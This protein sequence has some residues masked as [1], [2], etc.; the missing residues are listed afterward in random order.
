MA[1]PIPFNPTVLDQDLPPSKQVDNLLPAVHQTDT[2]K[3]FFSSS[4][5]HLFKPGTGQPINGYIGEQPSY[6]D[7]SQDY[8][9][10][11]ST[12]GRQFYQ[13]EP[14][15]VGTDASGNIDSLLF[16]PDIVNQLRF[17]G[18]LVGNHNRLFEQDYYSWCPPIDLD[19]LINYREYYW[20][21]TNDI[22]DDYLVIERGAANSN[23]WSANNFWYHRDDLTDSQKQGILIKAKRPIVEFQ[24]DLE[25]Y[26]YGTWR[27]QSVYVCAKGLDLSTLVLDA[28]DASVPTIVID[29]ITITQ[30]T[31]AVRILVIDDASDA[32]SDKVYRLTFSLSGAMTLN[33][34]T[35]GLDAAGLPTFGEVILVENGTLFGDQ[36]LYY[37]GSSW[38]KGQQKGDI[39]TSPLFNLYDA[40]NVPLD[41]P[42]KYPDSNFAGNKI[43]SYHV[44]TT[45]SSKN[46][47]VLG[48]PLTF[49]ANGQINF[50]NHLATQTYSYILNNAN[51][52]IT[53][54][55]FHK[56]LGS[57]APMFRNDWYAVSVPSRQMMVDQ[58]ICDGVNNIFPI[59]QRPDPDT[60]G[61]PPNLQVSRISKSAGA[62]ST[63]TF[64]TLVE[65]VDYVRLD[66][67]IALASTTL[68]DFIK[69]LSFSKAGP[70]QSATGFYQLP[71]NLQ[72]NPNNDEVSII[73]TGDLYQQFS[74]VM[75][76]QIGFS[77]QPYA[78]NNWRTTNRDLSKGRQIVQNS[79]NLLTL[80]LTLQNPNLDFMK[81]VRYTESEYIRFRNK[82]EQKI[83]QYFRG[84]KSVEDSVT[85]TAKSWQDVWIDDALAE[86]NKG[87][88]TAFPFGYSRV[89][90]DASHKVPSFIPPSPT[91][92]GVYPASIPALAA[93]YTFEVA[94]DNT[95][96]TSRPKIVIRNHDGSLTP[97]YGDYRVDVNGTIS[98]LGDVVDPRDSVLLQLEWR[99]YNSIKPTI[100]SSERPVYDWQRYYSGFFRQAE[101]SF[102][103]YHYLLQPAFDRW[104]NQFGLDFRSNTT[105]KADD[106]FTWNWSSV[107]GPDG[108]YLPGNWRGICLYFFDTDR[109]HTAP[110]EMLGFADKPNYWDASY[111]PA[112]YTSNNVTMWSDLENGIIRSGPR[113]G[114]NSQWARPGLSKY[115]PVDEEGNLLDPAQFGVATTY[116]AA[117]FA[118]E[119][120]KFGDCGPVE[121][122]WRRSGVFPFAVAQAGYLMKPARFFGGLWNSGDYVVQHGQLLDTS[123]NDRP[124]HAELFVHGEKDNSGKI[125]IK[126]GIQQWIA[127]YLTSLNQSITSAF[128]APLRN[129]N[130]KLAYKVG[131]F[132]N[133]ND[134]F[135]TSDSFDR[136]PSEDISVELYQSPSIR[137]E[138]YSGVIITWDGRWFQ[139]YGYDIL[140]PAFK[141]IPPNTFGPAYPIVFGSNQPV[142]IPN[143]TPGI[144]Y[145]VST[146]VNHAGVYYVCK[147]AHTATHSFE[148]NFWQEIPKPSFLSNQSITWYTSAADDADVVAVPYGAKLATLQEVGNFLNG[149]QRYY[150]SRGWIFDALVNNDFVSDWSRSCYEFLAWFHDN[151]AINGAFIALSPGSRQL[152]FKTDQGEPQS[153]EQFINGTY[154]LV[155][156]LSKPISPALV[157]I[158]RDEGELS[159]TQKADVNGGIFGCRLYIS[160][161]EHIIVLNNKT[162]FNDVIYDPL[163]NIK[164]PRLRLQGFKTINWHGRIDAP[165]F[166]VSGN[167][168]LPN[169]EK[170]ADEFRRM[171]DVETIDDD[172]LQERAR[173][174]I[175]YTERDYLSNLLLTPTNQ[176][177]FYQGMIQQKGTPTAMNRLLRSNFIRNNSDIHF[178]EEWLFRVGDYGS[179]EVQPSFELQ[180]KQSDVS[181]DPQLVVFNLDNTESDL[182]QSLNVIEITDL[183]GPPPVRDPRWIWRQD[184]G[185]VAWRTERFARHTPGFLPNWGYVNANNVSW[186]AFNRQALIDLYYTILASHPSNL[187]QNSYTF[188]Y[189]GITENPNNFR[190]VIVPNLTKGYLRVNKVEFLITENFVP[191]TMA[192]NVGRLSWPQEFGRA[193][194][195]ILASSPDQVFRPS[196][197][198]ELNDFDDNSIYIEFL[199]SKMTKPVGAN[200]GKVKITV[201]AEQF[202][203]SVLPNHR[204]AVY[205]D[206]LGDWNTYKLQDTKCLICAAYPPSFSGQGS[207]VSLITIDPAIST[208]DLILLDGVENTV[209][210]GDEFVFSSA[211]NPKFSSV[212]R[213]VINS[214]VINAAPVDDDG[215]SAVPIMAMIP[216]AGMVIDSLTFNVVEPFSGGTPTAKLKAGY[217]AIK[218][219]YVKLWTPPSEFTASNPQ[220]TTTPSFAVNEPVEINIYDTTVAVSEDQKYV[221]L[222]IIRSGNIYYSL[223]AINVTNHGSGYVTAPAVTVSGPSGVHA[224]A[225]IAGSV[226]QILITNGGSGFTSNPIVTI[227]G[228]Y[229]VGAQAYAVISGGSVVA[230]VVTA[231]G[232]GYTT[233]PQ[234]IISGGGGIGAQATATVNYGVASVS[235]L[236]TGGCLYDNTATPIVSFVGGGG[237][238]ASAIAQFNAALPP[239]TVNWRYYRNSPIMTGWTEGG[240]VT[241]LPVGTPLAAP[242]VSVS[243]AVVTYPGRPAPPDIHGPTP[244]PANVD[245]TTAYWLQTV[246]VPVDVPEDATSIYQVEIYNANESDTSYTITDNI[247]T[248][249]VVKT[250]A[251]NTSVDLSTLGAV[252]I[253]GGSVPT[254]DK[255]NVYLLPNGNTGTVVVNINYHY[256]LGFEVFYTD[257]TPA[258]IAGKGYGGRILGWYK[259][260]FPT[261][262][263]RDQAVIPGG[264][265]PQDVVEVDYVWP[266]LE[267]GGWATYRYLDLW[268]AVRDGV[269]NVNALLAQIDYLL[270]TANGEIRAEVTAALSELDPTSVINEI[271]ALIPNTT[272]L[273]NLL[274]TEKVTVD[275]SQ[276]V[277][278]TIYN[279]STNEV[280]QTLQLFDPYQGYIVGTADKE[281]TYK[282][283]YD[284]ASYSN[285]S[286]P[287]IPTTTQICWG[288]SESHQLWWDIS[289]VRYID[290]EIADTAYRWKNWGRLAPGA[291]VDV[292]EWVRSPVP[293]AAWATYT[294]AGTRYTGFATTPLSGSVRNPAAVGWCEHVEWI[295]ELNREVTAYYFWVKDVT[296]VPNNCGRALSALQVATVIRNPSS[297]DV[298]WFAAI[299]TNKLIISG[300]KQFL[301][302][303]DTILK[304]NWKLNN[305]DGVYHKQWKILREGDPTTAIDQFLWNKLRDSLVGW[306]DY[307][308]TTNVTTTLSEQY[309]SF[310][311]TLSVTDGSQLADSGEVLLAG[312]AVQYG[313]KFNNQL[314]ELNNASEVQGNSGDT[315]TQTV[316]TPAPKIVP[317]PALTPK[318]ANGTLVRPRQSWFKPDDDGH[319]SR[320]AIQMFVESFNN[321]MQDQP[322]LDIWYQWQ[323]VFGVKDLPPAENEFQAEAASLTARDQL[324][325]GGQIDFGQRVFVPGTSETN[326]FWT[327]WRYDSLN[328]NQPVFTL[329]KAQLYDFDEGYLWNRVDWYA[330]DWDASSFPLYHYPNRAAFEAA[331]PLTDTL[332]KGTLIMID[333]ES[334]TDPRWSWQ[335][336]LNGQYTQVAKQN[337]TVALSTAFYDATK[338][339]YGFDNFDLTAVPARDGAWELRMLLNSIPTKLFSTLQMNTLFF[340]MVRCALSLNG[341]IDWVIKSSFMSIG[342]FSEP[343][344]QSPLAYT[345]Q[346][347]NIVSYV[348]EVKPYHVKIRNYLIQ[349]TAGRDPANVHATDFDCGYGV[350][351]AVGYISPT[352]EY[353][354]AVVQ[355]QASAAAQVAAQQ[356][357]VV[358]AEGLHRSAAHTTLSTFPS[359]SAIPTSDWNGLRHFKTKVLFDRVECEDSE[360]AGWD[361]QPWD[362]QI[363][364]YIS[365][366]VPGTLLPGATLIGKYHYYQ[367]G[368]VHNTGENIVLNDNFQT[369]S[370]SLWDL[371]SNSNAATRVRRFYAPTPGMKTTNIISGCGYKGYIFDGGPSGYGL[372]DRFAWDFEGGL[373]NEA[374]YYDGAPDT[375]V[376][377]A[378]DTHA[379]NQPS[380]EMTPLAIDYRPGDLDLDG[381]KFIIDSNQVSYEIVDIDGGR[382]ADPLI[383]NGHPE[384]LVML[385]VKEK[386]VISLAR[387]D[388]SG[389]TTNSVWYQSN[390]ID[391]YR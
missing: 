346:L 337:A 140:N 271:T 355:A 92:L 116:P 176:F 362:Y 290:Y 335:V 314:F 302:D 255:L 280:L 328:N 31:G 34:E 212:A 373:A 37:T 20:V 124:S 202:V 49:D 78:S 331:P 254:D 298:A 365:V 323:T 8:Y 22:S 312:K 5:N 304:V 278:A 348:E 193:S 307:T 90:Y 148:A 60:P 3:R 214:D 71:Q 390:E 33:L 330:D 238:G 209:A 94:Y 177:E 10:V 242:A 164:Q 281:L 178:L 172:T 204:V 173:S 120:W 28:N 262:T 133:S 84:G 82:F 309:N 216:D 247:A 115:I 158:A 275:S 104:V 329:V 257:G 85:P 313:Y 146:T 306:D 129:L 325:L 42:A 36:E 73:S 54:F 383:E 239:M 149:L 219:Y 93:D 50:E 144:Y 165:G 194:S 100:E 153:V 12:P 318:E 1:T 67:A 256:E 122:T 207:P 357:A 29:G 166:V 32:L 76:N 260:R 352:R 321:L 387:Q 192:I 266:V 74:Q 30:A 265:Q 125:V 296:T 53:G 13:L 111:G 286:D 347:S 384:E 188:T 370:P 223:V 218:D 95:T 2:I 339:R 160:E 317:D 143:W 369:N 130:V 25:L 180:L 220:I 147:R 87:K 174:N 229:G 138:F 156:R 215:F 66:G 68:N 65:N 103:E 381:G 99:I 200:I 47:L 240:V 170:S 185:Q 366:D 117:A 201:T 221:P 101:Y 231:G 175:G 132:T 16:Y 105:F 11:E 301:D 273:W 70:L 382:F 137:E 102:A 324:A 292:Y 375:N 259:T 135:V 62:T 311:T 258:V 4:A 322:F 83:T 55:Y 251:G 226:S 343:L 379:N 15:M 128:G 248:I 367:P 327:L 79:A 235:I 63:T 75:T 295:P 213:L 152:R 363:K 19:K 338:T 376:A 364:K 227:V 245:P 263:A 299:D 182:S 391:Q 157:D 385:R 162:I 81:S 284:P 168:L 141:T 52:T 354:A 106:P 253:P 285:A 58:Y 217:D 250:D 7:P 276:F 334:A 199:Y 171:F 107:S 196:A 89:G 121:A 267:T 195:E 109:P 332:L 326:N 380:G 353:P 44:D 372:F 126:Y 377:T 91:F 319:P 189:D 80:C 98:P 359:V 341:D 163:L 208:T 142:N 24:K 64:T 320:Y 344:K 203:D 108:N 389:T 131:G 237:S 333:Q 305:N 269:Y 264:W 119:P 197:L 358:I 236:S 360:T 288:L 21:E 51:V 270:P 342:G 274:D 97:A 40:N 233:P 291:S 300:I 315:V 244:Q 110:W 336:Y 340:D 287:S 181:T 59:S 378:K 350:P 27:R 232:A 41:D 96:N 86:L 167:G 151:Q 18:A 268:K 161:V 136:V 261:V 206:I 345:D 14:S 205:T 277:N 351:Q 113:A 39:N 198:F 388:H 211:Y 38:K 371:G 297:Q 246:N 118:K 228:G 283:N 279:D 169:F 374:A 114:T 9:I 127:D 282:L 145:N 249:T 186:T 112:P 210:E 134:L 316:T 123:T 23:P 46:D 224:V 69:I 356:A 179:A 139:V 72:A 159:I 187:I 293:P 230:V 243:D 294:A 225:N 45:G 56:T 222:Q 252:T 57:P 88:T 368:P 150:T 184:K 155:N 272:P 349:Y 191:N 386:L 77:G 183:T 190:V 35:D 234:V 6:Y 289:T 43:F 361:L 241:F 308:K 303:S 154:S 26:D 61:E 17:Q 310:D 48:F